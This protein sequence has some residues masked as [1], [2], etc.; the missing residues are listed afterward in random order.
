MRPSGRNAIRHG[1]EN[2]LVVVIVN[3]SAVSGFVSPTLTWAHPLVAAKAAVRPSKTFDV[4]AKLIAIRLP[5]NNKVKNLKR[6]AGKP[7]STFE[8]IASGCGGG[9]LDNSY[10]DA[11][12][13][14]TRSS[15]QGGPT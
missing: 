11:A 3:G 8:D 6:P 4:F 14:R 7:R 12:T 1:N 2:V 5:V 9:V 13:S 15:E 10:A